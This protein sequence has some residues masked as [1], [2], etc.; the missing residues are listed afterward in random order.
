MSTL[1][2]AIVPTLASFACLFSKRV[3]E[4][5]QLLVVGAILTPGARTVAAI[6][7]TM[8]LAHE[9]HFQNYHRVLS[10]DVW[11]ARK[12][13]GILLKLIVAALLA[14]DAPV[15][16]DVDETLE[17]RRGARIAKKSIWHDPV[18]SS[19]SISV[20]SE[21]LRWV[22]MA[23]SV[24]VPWAER[25][26]ALPFFTVL[27]QSA[28]YDESVGR[29]HKVV[30]VLVEQ[31]LAQLRR[32][33]PNRRIVLVGDGAYCVADLLA[34]CAKR[35]ICLVTR[36]RWDAALYAPPPAR[37]AHQKGR[38]RLVGERL[39]KLRQVLDDSSTAWTQAEIADWYGGSGR[40]VEYCTGAALWKSAGKPP[41][42]IRWVIV[43]DPAPGAKS[44][45]VVLVCT[46]ADET[47]AAASP[48]Q[49]IGW[50]AHRWQ[51][52]STFRECRAHLGVETQRQWSDDAIERT[53]PVLLG[54]F[55]LVTL[56]AHHLQSSCGRLPMQQEAAWYD[57]KQPTFS[58][59]LAFV[60]QHLWQAKL[61]PEDIFDRSL[62]DYDLKQIRAETVRV[63][64][65]AL[66]RAV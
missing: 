40:V 47:R 66:A 8:G 4:R 16:I 25:V 53:T 29:H 23:V 60:R 13:A 49:I 46:D 56:M 26:W 48:Q 58:D 9:R 32:W 43:R 7:R 11:S 10:R 21:G 63:L 62:S 15:V 19:R 28:A 30:H 5:A 24:R 52:E 45:P 1:P 51:I 41:V 44:D 36:L 34:W 35:G 33:L 59:A 42:A 12:A 39:P 64:S 22:V 6:L 14:A 50:F 31:M 55:S 17:R 2:G 37:A 18:R 54:L 57:K 3:F 38:P 20:L 61:S 27:T 65:Q